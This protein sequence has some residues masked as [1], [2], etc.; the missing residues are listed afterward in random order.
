MRQFNPNLLHYYVQTINKLTFPRKLIYNV[1]DVQKVINNE[2]F[3]YP[4]VDVIK[5]F[6][7]FIEQILLL[8]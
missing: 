4:Q 1:Y 7:D 3:L 5:S 2:N 8:S 6:Y